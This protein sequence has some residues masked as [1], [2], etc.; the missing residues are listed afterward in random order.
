MNDQFA[1]QEQ[2]ET[3]AAIERE[4][5]S[6]QTCHGLE[7]RAWELATGID[8]LRRAPEN[9]LYLEDGTPGPIGGGRGLGFWKQLELLKN[10]NS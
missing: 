8:D 6:L 10:Q 4:T 3:A 5:K 2:L 7:K 1:L 9:Q